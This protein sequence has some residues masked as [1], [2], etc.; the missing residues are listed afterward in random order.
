MSGLWV[1]KWQFHQKYILANVLTF[2]EQLTVAMQEEWFLGG[3]DYFR[4]LLPLI[5][6]NPAVQMF[7]Q[8]SPF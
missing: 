6:Q 4:A 5:P 7:S 8:K 2:R 3:W 1:T